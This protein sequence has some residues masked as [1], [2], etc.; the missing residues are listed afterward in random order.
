MVGS[1]ERAE[2][3]Q[4]AAD[5]AVEPNSSRS[6]RHGKGNNV[7]GGVD[8]DSVGLNEINV[9]R[10][11]TANNIMGVNEEDTVKKILEGNKGETNVKEVHAFGEV[12]IK[13][14]VVT[15]GCTKLDKAKPKWIR[16][17][18]MECGDGKKE[19]G[20]AGSILGKR[21]AAQIVDEEAHS[22][23]MVRELKRNKTL[24]DNSMI[25]AAGVMDHPCRSQ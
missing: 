15:E 5:T 9:E 6:V 3:K 17:P 16:V 14:S 1:E 2:G 20:G 12:N 13:N 4:L 21:G 22:E 24:G 8:P 25:I 18:R 11:D 19:E 7:N 23:A 10:G